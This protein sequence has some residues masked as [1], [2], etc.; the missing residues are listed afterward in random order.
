MSS[1]RT[2]GCF[3]GKLKLGELLEVFPTHVGVFPSTANGA[4]LNNRLPHARG[5][6]SSFVR[7]HFSSS[8]SSPRTWGCFF[9][10]QAARPY[11]LVFPTHVGVFPPLGE[12]PR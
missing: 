1:P 4:K 11:A 12:R 2:W 10:A 5:G 6:V 7:Y 8:M 9:H 3:L